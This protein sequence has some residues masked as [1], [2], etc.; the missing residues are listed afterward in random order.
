MTLNLTSLVAKLKALEA[1]APGFLAMLQQELQSVQTSTLLN[2]L[3]LLISPGFAG[4]EQQALKELE[5]VVNLLV[6]ESSHI[7]PFVDQLI[8]LL[9]SLSPAAKAA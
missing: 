8:A 2:H 6:S 9:A 4:V 3:L 7:L 5:V 1:E